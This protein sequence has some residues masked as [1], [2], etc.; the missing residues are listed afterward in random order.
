MTVNPDLAETYLENLIAGHVQD[1]FSIFANEA[2]VDDPLGGRVRGATG[3]QCYCSERQAWL[4]E[5]V[6]RLEPLKTTRSDRR[7]VYEA[8]LHLRLSERE[9]ALP[10]AV[11]GEHAA[12][13]RVQAIRVYHSL[14]PLEGAHRVRAPL[15]SR[16]PGLMVT[17]VIAEYQKALAAGDIEVIVHTFDPDGYFREPAGGEY[18]Y[19]GLEKLHVLMTDMLGTGGIGLEHCTLTD[20]GV[21]CA[22]EFNAVR[23]GPHRIAP[24]AGIAVYERGRS[25]R[26]HAA[27]IYDDVNVEVLAHS[28]SSNVST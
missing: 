15:L 17:D 1:L 16:D 19:Q 22:I 6:A 12:D 14:W 8:L 27:R 20:D 9:I 28:N 7:T 3:F 5:R 10:V 4:S 24:Q 25:G 13:G 11:A 2:V 23:F 18:F 26:L 21:A